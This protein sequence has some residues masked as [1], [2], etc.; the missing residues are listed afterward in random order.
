MCSISSLPGSLWLECDI[1]WGAI[2]GYMDEAVSRGWQSRK[3]D[4]AWPWHQTLDSFT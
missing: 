4:V 1:G 2:A 3:T